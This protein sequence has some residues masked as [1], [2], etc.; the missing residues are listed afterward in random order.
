MSVGYLIVSVVFS[1][2]VRISLFPDIPKA[3]W[4]KLISII[5]GPIW[6]LRCGYIIGIIAFL[7]CAFYL[8]LIEWQSKNT[9]RKVPPICFDTIYHLVLLYNIVVSLLFFL[10]K[11]AAFASFTSH[12]M[13]EWFLAPFLNTFCMVII[14]LHVFQVKDEDPMK[15]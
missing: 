13:V 2:F 14:F 1:R 5:R 6:F 12:S 7:L 3:G 8:Y 9:S 11:L 15:A 10:L 4:E